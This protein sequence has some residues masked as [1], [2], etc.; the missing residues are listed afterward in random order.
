MEENL[1]SEV[2]LIV[3][4]V[5]ICLQKDITEEVVCEQKVH[6]GARKEEI[7]HWESIRHRSSSLFH[8]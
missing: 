2:H 5:R 7:Y 4:T 3:L 8:F 1:L 6:L